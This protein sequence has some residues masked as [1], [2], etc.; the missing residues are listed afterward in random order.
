MRYVVT[1]RLT[2][3]RETFKSS[4]M[5]DKAG[6]YMLEANPETVFEMLINHFTFITKTDS[7]F[8]AVEAIIMISHFCLLSNIL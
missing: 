4:A 8:A 3:S 5:V 6:K 7:Q 2:S 1:E